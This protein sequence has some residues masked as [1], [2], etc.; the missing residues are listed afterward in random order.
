MNLDC[1]DLEQVSNLSTKDYNTI[2]KAI[3]ITVGLEEEAMGFG[4]NNSIYGNRG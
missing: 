3:P 2:L 4:V 1:R